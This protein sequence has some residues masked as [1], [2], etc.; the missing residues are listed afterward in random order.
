MFVWSE[1][2]QKVGWLA[3]TDYTRCQPANR[4]R[5]LKDQTN[6]PALVSNAAMKLGEAEL[7]QEAAKCTNYCWPPTKHFPLAVCSHPRNLT[8]ITFQ[9]GNFSALPTR[10]SINSRSRDSALMTWT[11]L[12]TCICF[13]GWAR[14]CHCRCNGKELHYNEQL[15]GYSFSLCLTDWVCIQQNFA[16]SALTLLVE[17]QKEHPTC[18]NWVMRC[19]C[20]YLSEARCRLFAYGPADATAVPNPIISCLILIHSGF[21]FL[22]S[23]YPDRHGKEAAKWM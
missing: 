9:T 16:F 1:T 20:G 6:I 17:Q 14:T 8:S 22:V 12:M 7:W 5:R 3:A 4:L 11:R 2:S 10:R 19:W 18:K 21:T 13:S 23:A 15:F